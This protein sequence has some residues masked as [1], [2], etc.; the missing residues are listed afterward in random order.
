MTRTFAAAVAAFATVATFATTSTAS[1]ADTAHV[2]FAD[3]DLSSPDGQAKL[4][5]RIALAARQV[6]SEA[7]T[8]SRIKTVDAECVTRA[9]AS[10]EKQLAARRAS[11][12]NGG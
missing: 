2:R 8:G 10:I 11:S 1:A 3:L 4:D 9:R 6:C 7:Y 5:K 12:R